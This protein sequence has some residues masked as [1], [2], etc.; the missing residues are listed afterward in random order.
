MSQDQ[1]SGDE[2]FEQFERFLRE[3]SRRDF[4][5]RMGGAAAFIA[6]SAGAV[7]FLEA[8][9]SGSTTTS[10]TP[11][12]GG[13]VVE[14]NFSDVRTFN[15]MLSSDTA[16]NQLIGLMFDGLLN[17]KKNGDLFGA[18]A[19][20]LPKTSSDGLTYTFKLRPNLKWSDGQ[21][22]TADDV[23]FTY[24][25]A[26][27]PKYADVASPRRG[28]LSKYIAS[29]TA[30]DPQTVVITTTQVFAPFL[31]SHGQYGILPKH[32]LGSLSAKDINT[33]PF[34]SAPT[35]SNGP[36]KF[37]SWQS[38]QQVTLARNDSY[39]AGAP[40]LDQYIYKVLPDSTTVANQLKTGEIDIGPVDPAQYD[41]VKS[42][43][44]TNIAEFPVAIFDFYAYNLDPTKL[45]GK[46]FGQKEVR[47]A[48]VYALDRQ[49]WVQAIYF[50]HASVA[51]S[52]EPPT[53]WAFKAKPQVVY[54]FDKAKANSLLDGAGWVKG[55]D[56]MRAKDGL[57]LKF[58]M[59][60]NAG[61]KQRESLLQVMQQ[62]WKDIGVDATPK[63]I[64]FPQLVTEIVSTR[65]FD[66]FLVGFSWGQDPDEAPLFHS[67]NTIPGGFNGAD[68]KNP[69]VDAALDGA[70]ATLDQNKRKQLYYQF[71]D[72][73]S[74]QVPAPILMFNVGIWATSKRVMGA[75]F[76]TYNQ[77]GNRPW[78]N[79]VWVTDGK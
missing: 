56:G 5:R 53:S 17:S 7:E 32:V 38:G 30:P 10:L 24:Q 19:Q 75:D 73:M 37:V 79:K 4:L 14:G 74:D 29:V 9:A 71:Q 15:S 44:N 68:F 8:C 22:L 40:F 59:H 51:T 65:T 11:K 76:G 1:T 34:N 12:K 6:F 43:G 58:E 64:Q 45:G 41:S 50:G 21:P 18:L 47:Q 72:I 27:D 70:L 36:F 46:L 20:D 31:V 42:S 28:D 33:A 23:I 2:G 25:L 55:P 69:D 61:N 60:T 26:Y 77:F 67:R 39:W 13:H 49:S 35:V 63:L 66:M 3:W 52:V 57:P 48:L 78:I 62:S 16:S 54:G